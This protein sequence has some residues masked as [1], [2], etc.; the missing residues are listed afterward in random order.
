MIDAASAARK[1]ILMLC[2]IA[3]IVVH[4]IDAIK[5]GKDAFPLVKED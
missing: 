2:V 5:K 4:D 1:F 3:V